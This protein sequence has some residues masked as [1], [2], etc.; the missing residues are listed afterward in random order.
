[1]K[2]LILVPL[3]CFLAFAAAKFEPYKVLGVHR[4]ATQQE[5]KKAYKQMAKQW[6]PDKNKDNVAEAEERFIEVTKAYELLSDPDRRRQYDNHGVTE[7]TPNFRQRHD[8]SQYGRFDPFDSFFDDFFTGG[9]GGGF[10]FSFGGG[11]GGED[12]EHRIFHK[13]SITS[14]A[15]WNN[16]LPNSAKQP[17]LIMFYSDWCF[18]CIRVEPIWSR[19][20][21][22]LDPVGFGIAT[23]HSEHEKELTRKIGARELPHMIMLLD[24]KVIHYKDPQ[25]SAVK[26]LEFIRRKFPYKMVEAIDDSNVDS[27]LDGWTDNRVRVLLFGNVEVIRLRYLTTAFKYRNR[28][29]LGYVRIGDPA[30]RKTIERFGVSR[31]SDTLLL[32]QEH[33]SKDDKPVA[34]VTMKDLSLNTIYEVIDAHQFLQLPRLSSQEIFDTLCPTESTRS[35]K[36][37]CVTLITKEAVPEHEAYRQALREF[38]SE[39]KFSPDRVRFTYV[40]MER[41]HEFIKSLMTFEKAQTVVTSEEDPS[42]KIA[43]LWRR[44]TN[45]I[46]YEWF[47][48]PWKVEP[49]DEASKS[50]EELRKTLQRLLTSNEVLP[51][52]AELRQLFDEHTQSLF[53]RLTNKMIEV[54]ELLRENITKDEL[55]PA[56]SLVVTVGFIIVGGYVMS[57]L[58]KMEEESVQRQ[59]GAKGLKVDKKGKVVPELKVHELRAETYNG[60]VRLLKPGCRTI[61][62]IV[63]RE[64]KEKLVPKFYKLAWPYRRNKTLMFGFLYIEK[65]NRAVNVHNR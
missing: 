63:D 50:R 17:Y 11:R 41:Q 19:L 3:L 31:N 46:K 62:L 28:A 16:V 9:G 49:E 14:R 59:L 53:V 60:M 58:V 29:A 18:S 26:A 32:F 54:V 51:Y 35:R 37:L 38:V 56:I 34:S 47:K 42:L 52:E 20:T 21:E 27:F 55:L 23:V 44:D 7:D 1:M 25:F 15:Y 13:Q 12:G 2:I 36:R 24:G 33:G 57:Y 8:Y 43:I 30:A 6:H 48:T 45:K 22:E 39:F 40:L 5:I 61:V 4:R 10:K 64:S 65:G